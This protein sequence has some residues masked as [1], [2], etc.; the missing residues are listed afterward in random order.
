MDA[1]EAVLELCSLADANSTRVPQVQRM[2][3][4]SESSVP[5]QSSSSQGLSSLP[6]E[7]LDLIFQRVR[8]DGDQLHDDQPPNSR[9]MKEYIKALKAFLDLRLLCSILNL[10]LIPIAYHELP[11]YL[12]RKC[13]L[14]RIAGAFQAAAPHVRSVVIYGEPQFPEGTDKVIGRG[15]GLCSQVRNLECYGEHNTFTS[16][17]WAKM[18]HI[19]NS[20]LSSLVIRP[21]R[22]RSDLSHSLIALG[23]HLESLMIVDW[24]RP[25]MNSIFCLPSQMPN[26]TEL[27]ILGGFPEVKDLVKLVSRAI[28]RKVPKPQRVRLR[29]LTFLDVKMTGPDIMA[30][31]STNNLSSHLTSLTLLLKPESNALTCNVVVSVMKACTRLLLLFIFLGEEESREMLEHL[32]PTLEHLAIGLHPSILSVHHS[33]AVCPEDIEALI[34]SGRCSALQEVLIPMYCHA[35]AHGLECPDGLSLKSVC[36]QFGVKLSFVD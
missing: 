33:P 20:T 31:L 1:I 10:V 6:T 35:H 25:F 21:S 9:G 13:D 34:T 4:S 23:S 30:V 11:I 2:T 28:K 17:R 12:N 16:P 3:V 32:P 29:S 19:L 36:A 27:V 14:G 7:L 5:L 26:L 22:E 15:L 24:Q 8:P 18:A